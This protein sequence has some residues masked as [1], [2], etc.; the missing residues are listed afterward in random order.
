MLG[1]HYAGYFP[2]QDPAALALMRRRCLEGPQFYRSLVE[3]CAARAPWFTPEAE[4]SALLAARDRHSWQRTCAL[5]ADPTEV[6]PNLQ[7][8]SVT[9][10]SDHF[11]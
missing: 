7:W 8:N 5:I 9:D 10:K 2:V 1:G 11:C 6:F 4:R 3:Q